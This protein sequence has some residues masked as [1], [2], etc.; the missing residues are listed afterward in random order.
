MSTIKT[1]ESAKDKT[2]KYY[3][4]LKAYTYTLLHGN[5]TISLLSTHLLNLLIA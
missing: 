4:I 5:D 1:I 3:Q 2:C